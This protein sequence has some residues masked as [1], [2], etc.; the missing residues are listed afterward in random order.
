M[1]K[2]EVVSDFLSEFRFAVTFGDGTMVIRE[3]SET[4]DDHDLV[5]GAA[6]VALLLFVVGV[7]ASIVIRSL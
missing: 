3:S 6:L 7:I 4:V 2:R 5:A 1:A